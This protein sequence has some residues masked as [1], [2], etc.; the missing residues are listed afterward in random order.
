MRPS[1]PLYPFSSIYMPRLNLAPSSS[2]HA[3]AYSY[4]HP[5]SPSTSPASLP[6][7]STSPVSLPLSLLYP[8]AFTASLPS[9][10]ASL[11]LL[12][13][14]QP[15][16]P[17]PRRLPST[18]QASP[19]PPSTSSPPPPPPQHPSALSPPPSTSSASL[20][21]PL[22]LPSIPNHSLSPLPSPTAP[23]Q[24][25]AAVPEVEIKLATSRTQARGRVQFNHKAGKYEPLGDDPSLIDLL[26]LPSRTP[27]ALAT[28]THD[29]DV[30]EDLRELYGDLVSAEELDR[31]DAQPNCFNFSERVS[32]TLRPQTKSPR[33]SES[34]RGPPLP[35]PETPSTPSPPPRRS[36]FVEN[37]VN[38]QGL[39]PAAKVVERM[40]N[41]NIQDEVVQE[42]DWEAESE[43]MVCLY[44]LKNP[45]IVE[46]L[47]PVP[48]GVTSI[49]L[50]P[51]RPSV[52]VA[53]RTDGE[54]MVVSFRDAGPPSVLTSSASMGKHLLPVG[55]VSP[56]SEVHSSFSYF[57]RLSELYVLAIVVL[58]FVADGLVDIGNKGGLP[59]LPSA[60][61]RDRLLRGV[62][63]AADSRPDADS[64]PGEARPEPRA[65]ADHRQ[66]R[67]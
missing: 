7:P 14:P 54:V 40:A 23:Q 34:D 49:H 53:G 18:L 38:L 47:V 1:L 41:Q 36:T 57:L 61:R 30:H 13:I 12:R 15:S 42:G 10:P 39:L 5:P 63:V 21:P 17:S 35:L 20:T 27:P 22:H 37:E 4:P 33:V 52:L 59:V 48:R 11:H 32:Q 56:E 62:P 46:R 26:T 50:H 60:L 6:T 24:R 28:E 67:H 3:P 44:T 55:Q 65:A 25:K 9:P 66:R 64:A 2:T 31:L 29:F 51:T 43:G 58:G 45:G 16:P 19:S 8:A